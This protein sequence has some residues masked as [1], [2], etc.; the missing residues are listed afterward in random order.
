MPQLDTYMYFSQVFWLI[1]MF[2][3]FY[4]LVLNNI[5]PNI[6]RV[7]KLRNKQINASEGS[8]VSKEHEKVMETTSNILEYSLQDSTKFLNNVRNASSTWLEGSLKETN[9]KTLVELNKNYLKSIGELKG[10]SLLINEI[11]K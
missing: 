10:Q 8:L 2:T 1:I 5:L 9:E 6:A 3:T 7:L 11:I 4:I